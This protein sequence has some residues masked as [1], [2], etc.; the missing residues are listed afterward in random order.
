MSLEGSSTDSFAV[1]RSILVVLVAIPAIVLAVLGMRSVRAER[2][3]REQDLRDR[4]AQT[5][6]LANAGIR[7]ALTRIEL[8]LQGRD[9]ERNLTGPETQDIDSFSFE[10]PGR[11][12]FPRDR[13]QFGSETADEVRWSS[14]VED[15]VERARVAEAQQM[16]ARAAG[17][18]REI[19]AVEPRLRDWARLSIALL[20]HQDDRKLLSEISS[21]AVLAPA[22][23]TPGGLPL[24]LVA[25][26]SLQRKPAAER[27]THRESIRR[28]LS[29]L[30]AGTWWLTFEERRFYDQQLGE[31]LGEAQP[32]ADV[33]LNELAGIARLM[34]AVPLRRDTATWHFARREGSPT[35]LVVS[36]SG[37]DGS[38]WNGAAIGGKA[39]DRILSSVMRDAGGLQAGDVHLID[40]KEASIWGTPFDRSVGRAEALPVMHGWQLVFRRTDTPG[41]LDPR[42][43][44]WLGL[45]VLLVAT[46]LA[47]LAGAI[48]ITRR[49]A[50][51]ARMQNDFIAGVSHDF[52]SPITAL[53]LLL[54]RIS[55][56]RV[57]SAEALGRYQ[58]AASRE[59]TR[60]E[61]HVNRLLEAQRIQAGQRKYVLARHSPGDIIAD[62]VSELATQIEEK[63][64]RIE[65]DMNDL[66][67][68]DLDR[69][70]I[71][72]AM[73]NLIANAVKYSP[74]GGRIQLTGR[75]SD[76]FLVIEVCDEGPGIAPEELRHVFRRFYRGQGQHQKNVSGTGL[77]LALVHAA[78]QGHGGSVGVESRPGNG[79]RFT[80]RLPLRGQPEE[81][82]TKLRGHH[83]PGPH[84]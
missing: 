30:R 39:L 41:W 48:H 31:L 11:L 82:T 68:I 34:D 19:I 35:L 65:S 49:E 26:A 79:S 63:Q 52:K 29:Q 16:T 64:L 57:E 83:A 4:Q 81:L 27:A 6:R 47:S 40:D 32:G 70:A 14:R 24:P 7:H 84:C 60:L 45:V 13:L 61:R 9:S 38:Q 59:L 51:L 56:G 77:G 2:L 53:R 66:P 15:L 46:M 76:R 8:A 78:V 28:T 22:Q 75:V 71:T 69:E 25:C 10:R 50:V 54:E 80:I 43:V 23:V 58:D 3:E 62:A 67:E 37:R 17:F 5:A 73:S 33:R 72:D 55:G 74:A 21:T 36:P 20:E 1:R 44:L 18:Y 12:V 42:M